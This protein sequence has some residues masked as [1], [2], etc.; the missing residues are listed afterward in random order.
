[1]AIIHL[2]TRHYHRKTPLFTAYRERAA[3]AVPGLVT[4]ELKATVL[5]LKERNLKYLGLELDMDQCSS[6]FVLLLLLFALGDHA[7]VLAGRL[8]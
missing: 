5:E 7:C 8:L 4:N 1:M 6:L 3:A 2:H